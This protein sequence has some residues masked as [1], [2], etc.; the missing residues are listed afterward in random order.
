MANDGAHFTLDALLLHGRAGVSDLARGAGVA[1]KQ[2]TPV[3]I[4][5]IE[6]AQAVH[7]EPG[8]FEP[9]S[10]CCQYCGWRPEDRWDDSPEGFVR[11]GS[12]WTCDECVARADNPVEQS[13][14][15]F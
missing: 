14:R 8:Q 6:G 11:E 10:V 7:D 1:V 15:A 4:A 9:G 3:Q 13:H 12:R 5:A 2:L